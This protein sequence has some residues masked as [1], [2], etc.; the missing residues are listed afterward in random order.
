MSKKNTQSIKVDESMINEETMNQFNVGLSVDAIPDITSMIKIIDNMLD[1]IE[2]PR[3]K[4]LEISNKDRFET[5][6]FTKYNDVLPMKIITLLI[7]KNRYANL[8]QLLDMLET[9]SQI[10]KGNK[11]LNEETQKFNEKQNETF[12]YPKFGGK[13]NFEQMMKK[14]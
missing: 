8:E 6:I 5:E 2:S 7:D 11:D 10:K 14:K 3:M 1:F 4:S 9:L 12:V 13:D